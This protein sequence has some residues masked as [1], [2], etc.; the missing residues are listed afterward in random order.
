[1][2]RLDDSNDADVDSEDD[3]TPTVSGNAG[4]NRVAWDL[5]G[6]PPVPLVSR[7]EVESNDG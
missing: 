2:R 6:E 4:F 7:A 5:T 3:A 1:M